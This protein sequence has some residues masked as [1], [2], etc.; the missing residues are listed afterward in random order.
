[1]INGHNGGPPLADDCD[2]R[3]FDIK[4]FNHPIFNPLANKI[5]P[6]DPSRGHACHYYA[7]H[8]L[9]FNCQYTEGVVI[10]RGREMA[11]Q[12]G[13]LVGA[14]SWLAER[15]NWTPKKVRVFIDRLQEEGFIAKVEGKR[16]GKHNGN[17][18]KTLTICNFEHF[19]LAR[20]VQGQA[21]GQPSGQARNDVPGKG[22]QLCDASP[23]GS[24]VNREAAPVEG[25]ALEMVGAHATIDI[26]NSVP[27][28]AHAEGYINLDN[29]PSRIGRDSTD[30][31][32]CVDGGVGETVS[33]FGEIAPAKAKRGKPLH[34]LPDGWEPGHAGLTYAI[35]KGMTPDMAQFEFESFVSHHKGKDTKF[36]D[37]GRAWQTWCQ[38]WVRYR[39]DAK[40]RPGNPSMQELINQ[41]FGK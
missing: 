25:Q 15:W 41:A 29:I 30:S 13:Q 12:P 31:P 4:M 14:I 17:Q 35:S 2:L 5:T 22:K 1:M 7:F 32:V 9:V 3:V 21:V 40:K 37:W 38:N 11:I 34:P 8:D 33:L 18:S 27:T 39:R 20:Y 6:L 23:D 19:L 36:V 28:R 26:L 24:R 16:Q 10:N